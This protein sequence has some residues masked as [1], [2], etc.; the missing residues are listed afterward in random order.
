MVDSL[1]SFEGINLLHTDSRKLHAGFYAVENKSKEDSEGILRLL[2]AKQPSM[3]ERF[4]GRSTGRP[5]T[6]LYSSRPSARGSSS[7]SSCCWRRGPTP[8]G[9]SPTPATPAS[10]TP[11]SS[12][13]SK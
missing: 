2:L 7:W 13:N 1:L 9:R 3:V 6:R 8:T 11:S 4:L 12:S 5:A 10:T